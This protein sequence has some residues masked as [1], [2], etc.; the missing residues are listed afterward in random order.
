LKRA[1]VPST[2]ALPALKTGRWW[3]IGFACIC[4]LYAAMVLGV[5]LFMRNQGDRW[6]P[7]TLVLFGPRWLFAIPLAVLTPV[8]L[9]IRRR[10]LCVLMVAGGIVVFPLMNFQVPWRSLTQPDRH[11]A[12]VRVLTCN[13]HGKALDAAAFA[14]LVEQTHPDIVAL[15]EWST[16]NA[17]TVFGD[18]GWY[19]VVEGELCLASR[20][21]MRRVES[22]GGHRWNWSGAAIWYEIEAPSGRIPFINVH[23][24]SP[25]A[26]F[27][28]ALRRGPEA[29]EQIAR[30]SRQRL[31]QAGDVG[32]AAGNLGDWVLMAGDFNLPTDS[33][34][35]R[36]TLS[37]FSDAF[38][39]AGFGF[40][41][42]Y[43]A[44]WTNTRID[45]ILSG[46]GWACRRCWVGPDVG[47]PHRP[48]IAE[49][50][51]VGGGQ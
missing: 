2:P 3:R 32:K 1:E 41:L 22:I 20:Y 43:H 35:Y 48:V 16:S 49:M 21:P 34:V 36:Q 12:V 14:V 40:G 29:P 44:K 23:L 50:E 28:M 24:E 13:T 6:W 17:A 7:A 4:W 11:G 19:F 25:H 33:T 18:G 15:Q 9:L 51:F 31:L 26:A 27:L 30:N 47:S 5:W 38:E 45:H 10:S 39:T 42:T 8:A 46:H 37:G